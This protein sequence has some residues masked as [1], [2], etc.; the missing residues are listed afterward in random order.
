MMHTLRSEAMKRRCNR[1]IG[2]MPAMIVPLFLLLGML[3]GGGMVRADDAP[4][5]GIRPEKPG[6]DPASNGYFILKAQ[7]GATLHDAVVVVNPGTVP[8]KMFLYPVDATT[9]QGGGAVYMNST[10]PRQ[11]VGAWI[12]LEQNE[13]DVAPQKQVTVGFKIA[14]PNETRS[15]QRLGGIAAQ[16]VPGAPVAAATGGPQSGGFGI[17]TVTRA[18]TAVLLT[19]GDAPLVPSL[20]ITGAQVAQVEG[21]PTLTLGIQ[22]DG[23]ALVKPKGAITVT[24]AAGATVLTNQFAIDTLVPQTTI[25]YPVQA[26]PPATPGTYKVHAT[27]DFGGS[28]PAAYYGSFVV[29]AQPMPT[30]V[31]AGRTRPG[32][33]TTVAGANA[34]NGAASAPGATSS[35][36]VPTSS[37][38]SPLMPI[39]SGLAGALAIAVVGL[40]VMMVRS[41]KRQQP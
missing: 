17:T 14:V 27:L 37:G 41:R 28:T 12:T 4:Q 22:N 39:L 13:V 21:L 32:Q 31:P 30:A 7:P 25:A 34:P 35:M 9:S 36:P 3:A 16:Y 1:W 5:Y 38:M 23:T 18:L 10:D 2:R 20:K 26:D 24:D 19:I 33:A 11:D 8:V 40:G 6:P 29:A 15:G